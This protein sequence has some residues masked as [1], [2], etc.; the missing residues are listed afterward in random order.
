M[1]KS[2]DF[3]VAT[4]IKDVELVKVMGLEFPV[5]PGRDNGYGRCVTSA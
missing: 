1:A 5:S 4:D 2:A 3:L